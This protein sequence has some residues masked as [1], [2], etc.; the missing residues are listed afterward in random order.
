[1]N[2]SVLIIEDDPGL[3][4]KLAIVMEFLEYRHIIACGH[5]E[6]EPRVREA[7]PLSWFCWGVVARRER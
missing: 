4:I 5:D 1:M 6:W 7:D 3:R 2:S